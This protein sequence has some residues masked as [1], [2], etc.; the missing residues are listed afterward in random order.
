MEILEKL[1]IAKELQNFHYF[2]RAFW[3]IGEPLVDDFPNLETAAIS[4]DQEGNSIQFLINSKFWESLNSYNKSFLICHEM[5][6]IVFDHGLRFKEH[7]NKKTFEDIN[8]AADI[9]I[10]EMLCDSF[11][12]DRNLLDERI[13]KK[14]CWI[15]T[16]FKDITVLKKQ[17]T[18]YYFNLLLKNPCK[19][20]L[21]RMDEHFVLSD[22]ELEEIKNQMNDEGITD[23]LISGNLTGKNI[24]KELS[25]ALEK[26][27]GAGTG[28]YHSVNAKKVT[29][30]KWET[31]I[32]KWE[33]NNIKHTLDT[34]E[35]WE[36]V[37]NRYINVI[38][39]NINLP[40]SQ[41]IFNDFKEKDMISVFFFLDT[42]GSCISLGNRFF[43][44]AKSLNPKKFK[45]RLFCFDTRV[46]ET[47]LETKRIYGGG[48]TSFSIIE[49]KIQEI[50]KKD[51]I[52]YPK[53][54][55]IITDGYGNNVTPEKPE[56]WYWFLTS[57][58]TKYINKK[59]KIFNLKYFE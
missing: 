49:S 52:K 56:K 25:D 39:D 9:V 7:L 22:E 38:P 15:D 2:F 40:S 1:D 57:K 36:R 54:V 14:G 19:N 34:E 50:I 51:K 26:I 37:N 45:I 43:A 30:K 12:F 55:F 32:K 53:A 48:G 41:K 24:P 6:H 33:N 13:G 23:I 58:F 5:S 18:E 11:G 16:V 28:S 46:E 59:S 21:F 44:A 20:E 3:D 35:R 31:V 42:S 29:K 47:S 17:T 4:F 27:A 8:V 10:N